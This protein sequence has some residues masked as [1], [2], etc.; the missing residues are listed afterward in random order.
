[1]TKPE[2]DLYLTVR[3]LSNTYEELALLYRMSEVFSFLSIDEI[4]ARIVEEAVGTIG[5]TTAAVLFFEEGRR[6]LYTKTFKGNWDKETR[7]DAVSGNLKKVI[8]T[9]KS[10]VFCNINETEY[11]DYFPGLSTLMLCPIVGKEKV[12]GIVVA[13]DKKSGEEFYSSDSKLLMAI[14]AQAGLAIENAL[15]YHEFESLM[16]GAISSLVK[17]LEASSKWTAGHTERVTEY[18]VNIGTLMGLER[19][20]IERLRITALLHDIGKIAT[21]K[22]ILNKKAKLHKNEWKEIKKHPARGADI[23]KELKQFEDIT[24]S[25]K[26]HHECWD[27]CSGIYGLQKHEIPLMARILAFADT[28]DAL[29]S[30]RPYRKKKTRDEAVKEIA[31]C[32]GTQ[33]DPG[34]VEAFLSWIKDFSLPR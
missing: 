31:R 1:M 13:S 16:L 8:G 21:P 15:L 19:E 6:E 10:S 4:C 27:G 2:H 17:T 7:Y 25:I 23:L 9:K 29:T 20:L 14:S 22:E 18:A 34:V 12:L 28:F 11:K 32:S 33:F 30:D 24:Q 3:E 26:Y 5:V